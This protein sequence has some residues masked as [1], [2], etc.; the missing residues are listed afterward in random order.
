MASLKTIV[1]AVTREPQPLVWRVRWCTVAKV[2]SIG[3]VVRR[4]T[5]CA[6]GEVV[7]G[8]HHVAVLAQALAGQRVLPG[9]RKVHLVE[10]TFGV[11]A[12]ALGQFVEDV[13]RLVYPALLDAGAGQRLLQ[14][15]PKAQGTIGDGQKGVSLQAPSLQILQQV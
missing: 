7:E 10:Q 1:K 4:W 3:L 9:G 5:Q 6:A 12:H 8:E 15:L 14:R 13:G 11:W 2:D